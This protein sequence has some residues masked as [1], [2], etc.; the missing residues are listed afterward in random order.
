MTG[1]IEDYQARESELKREWAERRFVLQDHQLEEEARLD[2]IQHSLQR[3]LQRATRLNNRI[4]NMDRAVGSLVIGLARLNGAKECLQARITLLRKVQMLQA[5][6]ERLRNLLKESRY[7]E[8]SSPLMATMQFVEA[9]GPTILKECPG[10]SA[11]LKQATEVQQGI[12][13]GVFE[14]FQANVGQRGGFQP[15]DPFLMA[16]AALLVEI[17]GPSYVK[18][19]TT[20][21]CEA[22]LKD[23][24]SVFRGH[25]EWASL[26]S[27]Q[28]RF[29]WLARLLETYKKDHQLV[30]LDTWKVP[31]WLCI[32]FCAL[33]AKDIAD[34]LSAKRD[35][36]AEGEE[37]AEVLLSSIKESQA[38]EQ[39]LRSMFP[40]AP[41][42]S[43]NLSS[44]FE[45]N[46]HLFLKIQ[47]TELQHFMNA[48]PK[49]VDID[50]VNQLVA[51]ASTFWLL[52]RDAMD[53]IVALDSPKTTLGLFPLLGKYLT[54][55]AAYL[56]EHLPSKRT[57]SSLSVEGLQLVCVLLNTANF[58]IG[59][60]ERLAER[61]KE[62]KAS[63]NATSPTSP[64]SS[65]SPSLEVGLES[66]LQAFHIL[67]SLCYNSLENHLNESLTPAWDQMASTIKTAWSADYQQGDRSTFTQ[68][69]AQQFHRLTAT[70]SKCIIRP[71]TLS[72]VYGRLAREH[73]QPVQEESL[74]L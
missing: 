8:I 38:M 30:F 19:L 66:A 61:A 1:L 24:K 6:I 23:Y 27:L 9:L 7:R 10:L 48:L 50:A 67:A 37:A 41:P 46:L 34:S 28:K 54:R 52:L 59:N 68:S 53:D 45:G 74:E 72:L 47:E 44:C 55:Y 60:G 40:D 22:Q 56:Q 57:N 70:L 49:N 5:G 39:K 33:T 69:I 21:Y 16:D 63:F 35:G 62:F 14:L 31:Q 26:T 17:L 13:Q 3:Q 43:F 20:W 36:E 51:S 32:H 2:F 25:P 11:V 58:C 71:D 73:H 12:W 42:G 4:V 29:H 18:H 65:S 15:R 64:A